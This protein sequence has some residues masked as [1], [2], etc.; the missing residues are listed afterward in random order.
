MIKSTSPPPAKRG[1]KKGQKLDLINLSSGGSGGRRKP[2][3]ENDWK[4]DKCQN[5]LQFDKCFDGE[6]DSSFSSSSISSDESLEFEEKEENCITDM[7]GNRIISVGKFTAAVKKSMCCKKCAIDGHRK[8]IQDFLHFAKE[9]EEKI[10]REEASIFFQDKIERLEWRV[11]HRKTTSELYSMFCGKNKQQSVDDRVCKEFS[12]AEETYG[13]ATTMFG[14]CSKKKIAMSFVLT[15]TKFQGI[16]NFMAIQR[17]K[18][19]PSTIKL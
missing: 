19:L 18:N 14:L 15:Q 2:D 10:Q 3:E 11:E 12:I 9:Y 4:M 16:G 6:D 1:R 7:Q 8:Y 5:K 13:L 17:L